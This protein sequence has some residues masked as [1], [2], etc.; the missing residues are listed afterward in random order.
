M[1]FRSVGVSHRQRAPLQGYF[2]SF[3]RPRP[4]PRPR[5]RKR[6]LVQRRFHSIPNESK[7]QIE[8]LV[9]G[10]KWQVAKGTWEVGNGK[11]LVARHLSLF[12][13]KL[14]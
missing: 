14:H 2:Y 11:S 1:S 10:G 13:F 3:V 5:P 6:R 8:A 7:I 9:N 12:W 4:R